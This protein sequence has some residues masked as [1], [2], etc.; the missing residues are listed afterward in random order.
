MKRF[1]KHLFICENKRPD[2][3]PRGCCMSKGGSL[4]REKFRMR[5]KELGLNSTVRTNTS[6]CLDACEFGAVVLIY[7]EQIWYGNVKEEDVEEIIQSH[8][9]GNKPVERLMIKEKK[10]NLDAIEN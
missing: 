2:D 4:I 1:E 8:I 5:L 7:P 9:I 6:G 3:N 10:F